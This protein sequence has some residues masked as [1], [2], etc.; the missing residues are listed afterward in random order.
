VVNRAAEVAEEV[1]CCLPVSRAQLGH[2]SAED[3]D[4]VR[5]VRV[6]GNHKVHERTYSSHVRLVVVHKDGHNDLHAILLPDDHQRV[7]A[8]A[9]KVQLNEYLLE[10]AEPLVAALL[11]AVEALEQSGNPDGVVLSK[12]VGLL[13]VEIGVADVTR[14]ELKKCTDVSQQLSNSVQCQSACQ[15]HLGLCVEVIVILV[16]SGWFVWGQVIAH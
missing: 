6:R 11:E 13:H 2:E 1:L 5:N 9:G 16:V 14:L 8:D 4:G 7:G 12:A 15:A 10:T 3:A